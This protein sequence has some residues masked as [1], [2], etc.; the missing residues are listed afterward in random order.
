MGNCLLTKLKAAVNNPNLPVLE[1][2]QQFTLDA[3]TKSGNTSLTDVQKWALNHF[4]YQIGAIGNSALWG[5]VRT[6]FLPIIGVGKSTIVL[7]YKNE[8]VSLDSTS[9]YLVDQPGALESNVTLG[10]IASN[11]PNVTGNMKGSAVFGLAAV[12]SAMDANTYFGF[13]T[14]DSVER[15]GF[16]TSSVLAVALDA[17][18]NVK[19]VRRFAKTT[20]TAMLANFGSDTMAGYGIKDGSMVQTSSQS[21]GTAYDQL[22]ASVSDAAYAVRL[23]AGV[24]YGML[25]DFNAALTDAEIATVLG[26]AI[27]LRN[28]FI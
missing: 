21:Y 6:L 16:V 1:I 12:G 27:E 2:M 7:D 3:I 8:N 18:G 23:K 4:F 11:Y 25:I 9:S 17:G 14:G 15:C 20:M 26:A 5:K 22:N 28:A 13:K 10:T 24:K 19:G